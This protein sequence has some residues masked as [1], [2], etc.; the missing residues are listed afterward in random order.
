MLKFPVCRQGCATVFGVF[1][2][3]KDEDILDRESPLTSPIGT[4]RSRRWCRKISAVGGRADKLGN[5]ARIQV[6]A[7]Q[8]ST[9]F[10]IRFRPDL[11]PATASGIACSN[12]RFFERCNMKKLFMAAALST[13]FTAAATAQNSENTRDTAYGKHDMGPSTPSMDKPNSAT[14][15]H[16]MASGSRTTTKRSKKLDK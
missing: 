2:G 15:T 16:G 14:A 12:Q 4:K 1:D 10:V 13:V 11:E 7:G 5:S 9:P 8:P 3:W 6:R